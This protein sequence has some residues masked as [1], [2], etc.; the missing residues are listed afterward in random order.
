MFS[1]SADLYDAVYSWKDYAREAEA[2]HD[3]IEAHRRS[4]GRRLL[5]V[6]CGTGR[7][8]EHLKLWYDCEGCDLD[9]AMLAVARARHPGLRLFECDMRTLDA[10]RRYDAVVCL[11]SAIG[12]VGELGPAIAAL[13]RHVAPGGVLLVE[14]W[15]T[16]E[17]VQPPHVSAIF[18]DRPEL[19]VCRMATGVVEGRRMRLEFEYLV[20]REARVERFSESHETWLHTDDEYRAAFLEAGLEVEHDPEGPMGRGLYIGLRRG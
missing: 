19:K 13:G 2:V 14:P 7:H 11:F 4:R 18:V 16:P 1:R 9:P 6:A 20:G 17:A 8:L 10:G 15:L 12:Y 3:A 5:D